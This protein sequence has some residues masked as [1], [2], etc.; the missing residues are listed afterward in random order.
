MNFNLK[1]A[2]LNNEEFSKTERTGQLG[3]ALWPYWHNGVLSMYGGAMSL[4]HLAGSNQLNVI[5]LDKLIDYPSNSMQNVSSIIHIHVYHHDEIFSKFS[6]KKGMYDNMMIDD[7]KAKSVKF[8]C[9]K[10][11]IESKKM[12]NFQLRDMFKNEVKLNKNV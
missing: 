5:H 10:I 7:K 2:Y 3:A 12:T 6:F 8:Y 4:N 11:A 1:K 9:L